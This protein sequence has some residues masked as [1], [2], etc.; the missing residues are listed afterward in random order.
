MPAPKS[1]G[2]PRFSG[3]GEGGRIAPVGLVCIVQTI[4]HVQKVSA[5]WIRSHCAHFLPRIRRFLR[6]Y[7]RRRRGLGVGCAPG[8]NLI[9]CV[10]K[11]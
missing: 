2:R 1:A 11:T 4:R 3:C 7:C 9:G 8:R 5:V 10:L 6:R